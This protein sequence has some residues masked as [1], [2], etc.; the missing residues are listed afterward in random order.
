MISGTVPCMICHDKH[1]SGSL[2]Q[3]KAIQQFLE[4]NARNKMIS[5]K[6]VIDDNVS[7]INAFTMST[8]NHCKYGLSCSH[9]TSMTNEANNIARDIDKTIVQYIKDA[10]KGQ[11]Y[12]LLYFM[13][14]YFPQAYTA[15]ERQWYVYHKKE[16]ETNV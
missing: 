15:I 2:E 8:H 4:N 9:L 7:F 10:D 13:R 6:A 3:M 1:N 5:N 11:L 14:G 16:G 12:D